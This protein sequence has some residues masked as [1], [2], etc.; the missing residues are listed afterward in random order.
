MRQLTFFALSMVAAACFSQVQT[1]KAPLLFN[2][3]AQKADI[4]K[5]AILN[6]DLPTDS[7]LLL[8]TPQEDE[9]SE[10]RNIVTADSILVAD[11]ASDAIASPLQPYNFRPTVFDSF[12]YLDTLSIPSPSSVENDLIVAPFTSPVF[13]ADALSAALVRQ[14]KQY[15]FVNHPYMHTYDE[16]SLPEPPKKF[17]S[18]VDPETAKIVIDEVKPV[19]I[20][21]APV[22]AVFERRHW[23]HKFNGEI[24]F[25]QAYVSPNWYQGGNN[26]LNILANV[27]Y[28]V[29][30]NPAFHPKLLFETTLQ[31]K[32]GLNNA[33][34]DK[35]R[36]YNISEDIFQFNLLAGYKASKYWYY[37]TNV[38]F[39]TQFL[40]NYKP[41]TNDLSGA[42][43][44][45]GE[46]NVG[47]GM[48]Y[49]R[50]NAKKTFSL[51]ASIDPLSWN[52]KTC[53][54]NRM[55]ETAY[56]IKAGRKVV[57]EIGSSAEA[58]V[59]WTICDNVSMRSRIFVFTDYAYAYGDWE[60]TFSFTINRFLS[61]QIYV[62]LR[63]DSST[64]SIENPNWHKLQLKEILSF[65][66]AYKF[67]TL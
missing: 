1:L 44:S 50:Q 28:N 65:G 52:M 67:S 58:K 21:E 56:G 38:S 63:Y 31:Y 15:L 24:Q 11:I 18:H 22:E 55:D 23:L 14:A 51:D 25:S 37:S 45:P 10:I 16:A 13:E 2:T 4:Y 33:P 41:N 53:I 5:S 57:N 48:T 60:N 27:Y 9:D 34:E 3:Q 46:L 36:N 43:L 39:K 8:L 49:N 35:V 7:L 61:T 17:T 19:M 62:H 26:N 30:L 66:F 40:N 6:T 29:K 42:L 12:L 20:T 54:N 59:S 47:V 64:P 32:L